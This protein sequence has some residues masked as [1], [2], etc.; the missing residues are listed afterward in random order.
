MPRRSCIMR[1][2][3]CS[4]GGFAVPGTS[5]CP[6]HSGGWR[7]TPEMQSRWGYYN[8]SSWRQHRAK[9]LR[10]HPTCVS[11]EPS[12]RGRPYRADRA[13][14]RPGRA[15]AVDVHQMPQPEVELRGWPGGES[16]TEREAMTTDE[17]LSVIEDVIDANI[18][19][20]PA[21][22]P[23][24]EIG[25]W[26]ESEGWPVFHVHGDD[27]DAVSLGARSAALGS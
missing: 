16:E 11:A 22:L 2:P 24:E 15:V 5:R 9:Q 14:W 20:A 7:K 25:E 19:R 4:N 8:T 12:D 10:E 23:E 6:A 21:D 13:R 27:I 1:G 17:M 18:A 26:V 3:K